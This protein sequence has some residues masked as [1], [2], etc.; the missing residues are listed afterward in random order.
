MYR[1]HPEN[2]GE[3]TEGDFDN[4]FTY[5]ATKDEWALKHGLTCE[6][7]V[8]HGFCRFAIIKKTV[9]YICVDQ[10]AEGKPV[11]EKWFIKKHVVFSKE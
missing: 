11:L 9:A 4:C 7:D 2:I 1:Y 5:R 6:V 3:F 8:M 10:D